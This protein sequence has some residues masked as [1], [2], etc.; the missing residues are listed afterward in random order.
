MKQIVSESMI[1][2]FAR[3]LNKSSLMVYTYIDPMTCSSVPIIEIYK[4]EPE[5]ATVACLTFS[6]WS[7]G[8][9]RV[10]TVV[11]PTGEMKNTLMSPLIRPKGGLPSWVLSAAP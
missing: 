4:I 3:I 7:M 1:C 10:S 11:R 8:F 2:E 9:V 5:F 6:F